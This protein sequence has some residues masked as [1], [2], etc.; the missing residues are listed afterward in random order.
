MLCGVVDFQSR[1]YH[2]GQVH[3]TERKTVHGMWLKH[4]PHFDWHISRS[5]MYKEKN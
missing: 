2:Q 3:G 4:I 1:S 5:L